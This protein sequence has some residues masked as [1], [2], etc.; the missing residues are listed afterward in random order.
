MK[1]ISIITISFVFICIF[2]GNAAVKR[3]VKSISTGNQNGLSWINAKSNIQQVINMSAEGDTV[4]IAAGTYTG[5]FTLKQGVQIYGGFSGTE[6][7]LVERKLPG[8]GENLTILDGNNSQRVVVQDTAFTVATLLD[9]FIIQNGSA[10]FGAGISMKNNLIL[11]R[12]II[13]DNSAGEI[14]LGDYLPV[15]GG[16]VVRID[17]NEGKAF[18]V[19]T[20]NHGQTYQSGRGNVAVKTVLDSA[21][22]D[23]NGQSNTKSMT[24]ASVAKAITEFKAEAPADTFTDWYIPSAGEWGMLISGGPFMG[25][26]SEICNIVEQAL[27]ANNK[28]TFGTDKYWSSTPATDSPYPEM[29]YANFSSMSLNSISA[30]QYNRLRGMRTFPLS[31]GFGTGGGVYATSGAR[32]EGCLIYNNTAAEG[33][34]IYTIG[35]VPVHYSTVVNNKQ[36]SQGYLQSQGLV[37]AFIAGST[38]TTSVTNSVIWGNKDAEDKPSNLIV[39]TSTRVLYSAWESVDA[40]VGTGNI[41][42]PAAN[43]EQN[44][45]Q[46]KNPENFDFNLLVNSVCADTGDKRRLPKGLD[47]DLNGIVRTT[48]E[49]R[50]MGAYES[51]LINSVP[52]LMNENE[53]SVY[54]NPVRRGDQLTFSNHSNYGQLNISVINLVG[55]VISTTSYSNQHNQIQMP[56]ESGTY[57]LIIMN[58]EGVSIKKIITVH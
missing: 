22:L 3:Y 20:Q 53:I 12:C 43:A 16:V 9:G 41:A 2:H 55:Q 29:W 10:L 33:S 18:V 31:R 8:K 25:G 58:Y 38:E 34:G 32:I 57:I 27:T 17:K 45:M 24:D 6:T 15:Q 21:L 36:S 37:T 46:F 44:G 35:N 14:K 19:A 52:S 5:G 7:A 50:S 26:R 56:T 4:W 11:R 49:C 42:L 54:P 51:E 30:L 47:T 40:V 1:H 23:K 48:A 28:Q 39:T 13:R